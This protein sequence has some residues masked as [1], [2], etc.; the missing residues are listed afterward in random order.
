MPIERIA[1]NDLSD[2][3]YFRL[4]TV[5]NDAKLLHYE[6]K[7]LLYGTGIFTERKSIPIILVN[8]NGVDGKWFEFLTKRELF[9]KHDNYEN[10]DHIFIDENKEFFI[11]WPIKISASEALNYIEPIINSPKCKRKI[12]TFFDLC[13]DV[14]RMNDLEKSQ[15]LIEEQLAKDKLKKYLK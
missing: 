7:K 14:K 12:A 2:E 8:K 5:I 4:T 11:G 3:R 6:K 13:E 9:N 10:N 1:I 15:K